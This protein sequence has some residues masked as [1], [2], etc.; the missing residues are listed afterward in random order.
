MKRGV[1]FCSDVNWCILILWYSVSFF[2]KYKSCWH[3][4][5][6][7]DIKT[8]HGTSSIH[9]WMRR[10]VSSLLL[11]LPAC[12]CKCIRLNSGTGRAIVMK[13]MLLMLPLLLH[14][15][16]TLVFMKKVDSIC[17]YQR[18]GSG[19]NSSLSAAPLLPHSELNIQ[20]IL[21]SG[22]PEMDI[23]DHNLL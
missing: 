13:W 20:I 16:S 9:L 8:C 1:L 22:W 6:R 4:A 15:F 14:A 19:C 23:L 3:F 21:A 11:L 2:P 5:C 18:S 10:Y 7:G 12:Y 17:I